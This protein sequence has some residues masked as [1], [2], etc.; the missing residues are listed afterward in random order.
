[1]SNDK[2]SPK[3]VATTPLSLS[4]PNPSFDESIQDFV[5][6]SSIS[7]N[8]YIQLGF[9]HSDSLSEFP[10]FLKT[11][12][13]SY[14]DY[15]KDISSGNIIDF[16]ESTKRYAHSSGGLNSQTTPTDA[17]KD[18]GAKLIVSN[19]YP[20]IPCP[21]ASKHS[22]YI[23]CHF[24]IDEG[25]PLHLLEKEL[26]LRSNDC[27]ANMATQVIIKIMKYPGLILT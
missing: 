7:V 9:S 14:M 15:R 21:D 23:F 17:C 24:E 3:N 20:L 22:S 4:I 25:I 5:T 27:Q 12:A 18:D 6:D 8:T 1:M 16:D 26:L 2:P 11:F 19:I 10:N 13:T